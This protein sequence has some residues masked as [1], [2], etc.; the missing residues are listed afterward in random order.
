[1]PLLIFGAP[2]RPFSAAGAIFGLAVLAFLM[3][4]ARAGPSPDRADALRYAFAHVDLPEM[5]AESHAG[6]SLT[7]DL[8]TRA[9]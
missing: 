1:M 8:M 5:D 6:E 4:C 2:P 7:G 3:M 9:W